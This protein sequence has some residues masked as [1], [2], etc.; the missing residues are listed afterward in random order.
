MIGMLV[1]ITPADGEISESVTGEAVGYGS[2]E[3]TGMSLVLVRVDG[4]GILAVH[5]SRIAS[6]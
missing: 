5:R 1:T 3:T 2:D 4:L 6:A